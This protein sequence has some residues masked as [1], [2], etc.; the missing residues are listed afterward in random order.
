MIGLRDFRKGRSFLDE[1]ITAAR[2]AHD[3][4]TA[5]LSLT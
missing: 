4:L 1:C 3:R 2:F 5:S